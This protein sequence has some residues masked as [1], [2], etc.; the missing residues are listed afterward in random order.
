MARVFAQTQDYQRPESA[1]AV[2]L[3]ELCTA[4]DP[5]AP[6]VTRRTGFA[7]PGE[8]QAVR[9]TLGLPLRVVRLPDGLRCAGG[10][11]A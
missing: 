6:A 2:R 5:R 7:N 3:P 9:E 11:L 8:T 10:P 1:L 4:A